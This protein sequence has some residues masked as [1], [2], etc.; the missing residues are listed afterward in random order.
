VIDLANL[1]D[2]NAAGMKG[3]LAKPSTVLPII[4]GGFVV[5]AGLSLS[6]RLLKTA[7]TKVPFIGQPSNPFAQP[8]VVS[9]GPSKQYIG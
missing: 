2:F 5:L 8:Q 9:S 7:S 6:E 1:L 4:I 3:N